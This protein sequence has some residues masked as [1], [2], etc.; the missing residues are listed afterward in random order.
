MQNLVPALAP[1]SKES[2][3]G[4]KLVP[5]SVPEPGVKS[6]NNLFCL[7]LK[8]SHAIIYSKATPEPTLKLAPIDILTQ[9]EAEPCYI[10]PI[11]EIFFRVEI[12]L[13]FFHF[14]I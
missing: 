14:D 7:S 6:C 9:F 4:A 1:V 5:N 11:I 3:S 12:K 10:L 13:Y 2:R 8:R